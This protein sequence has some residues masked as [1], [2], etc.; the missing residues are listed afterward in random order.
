[1][2][3]NM[4]KFVSKIALALFLSSMILPQVA[5]IANASST[6]VLT[7]EGWGI[8]DKRSVGSFTV[9]DARDETRYT[10]NHSQTRNLNTSSSTQMNV[11][12]RK[13]AFIGSTNE[14][15]S[16]FTGTTSGSFSSS[17]RAGTYWLHF[18][19]NVSDVRKFDISGNVTRPR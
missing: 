8:F 4:K 19:F 15:S 12:F 13:S 7:Y 18:T 11:A 1:M 2:R 17:L 3:D 9:S 6:T 5:R 10:V 16:N 14:G